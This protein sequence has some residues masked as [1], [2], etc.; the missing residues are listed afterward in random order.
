M[1][2]PPQWQLFEMEQ[3]ATAAPR[4]AGE[5]GMELAMQVRP[6]GR[7][8]DHYRVT[9]GGSRIL[10]VNFGMA[11][12]ISLPAVSTWNLRLQVWPRDLSIRRNM[13]SSEWQNLETLIAAKDAAVMTGDEAVVPYE[14]VLQA[15]R[16]GEASAGI[17][18][19]VVI[20]SD[21]HLLLM[22]QGLPASA[23]YLVGRPT[24]RG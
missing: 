11:K 1:D 19:A 12:I 17:R 18:Y 16:I 10:D 14:E 24:F 5:L 7:M 15:I 21:Q 9:L 3:F 6:N 13:T 8:L 20:G 4:A 2:F 23:D 22:L